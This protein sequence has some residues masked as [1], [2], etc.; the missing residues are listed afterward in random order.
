MKI[1]NLLVFADVNLNIMD[2]SSV[3]LAELL[4]LLTADPVFSDFV[5]L[6]TTDNISTV[7]R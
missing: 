1:L 6:L 4:K 3:W 2:G 7:G 5:T